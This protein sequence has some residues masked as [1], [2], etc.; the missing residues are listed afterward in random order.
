M[1]NKEHIIKMSWDSFPISKWLNRCISDFTLH[2]ASLQ[3]LQGSCRRLGMFTGE[4]ERWS[5]VYTY[6][7]MEERVLSFAK[8]KTEWCIIKNG[9]RI[10]WEKERDEG[11]HCSGKRTWDL[12]SSKAQ[13]M[14]ERVVPWKERLKGSGRLEGEKR[15]GIESRWN[16]WGR[17]KWWGGD[18]R[19][20]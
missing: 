2:W 15:E 17:W 19:F 14:S 11:S 20:L 5:S 10:K 8:E 3:W 9:T 1:D 16:K 4:P 18:E 7:G 13:E 6:A 12:G